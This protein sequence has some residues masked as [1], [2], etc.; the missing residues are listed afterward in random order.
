[1]I[2]LI[3]ASAGCHFILNFLMVFVV[4]KLFSTC[5]VFNVILESSEHRSK[6]KDVRDAREIVRERKKERELKEKEIQREMKERE[7]RKREES[8]RER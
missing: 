6:T 5:I 4:N 8:I 2:S 3:V 7:A 1:M